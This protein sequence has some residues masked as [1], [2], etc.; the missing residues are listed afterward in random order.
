MFWAVMVYLACDYPITCKFPFGNLTMTWRFWNGKKTL[1][2]M[3]KMLWGF[4]CVSYHPVFWKMVPERWI[5]IHTHMLSWYLAL[6]IQCHQLLWAMPF[7][8][9]QK[10]DT[11]QENTVYVCQRAGSLNNRLPSRRTEHMIRSS[12]FILTNN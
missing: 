10:V 5:C 3:Q 12:N 11:N 8:V 2:Q 1:H 4:F 9:F 7:P 6:T